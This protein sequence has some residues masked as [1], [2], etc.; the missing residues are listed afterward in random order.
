MT[1][2]SRKPPAAPPPRADSFFIV[3]VGAS[4]GGLEA[5]TQ[6]LG[7]LPPKPGIALV[8]IQ[9]LNPQHHSLL[10]EILS[11]TARMPIHEAVDNRAVEP[12]CIY[13]I[14]PNTNISIT[15]RI[16]RLTP[17]PDIHSPHLS[18]DFFLRSLAEDQKN[19]AIGVILSGNGS[20]G[21]TGLEAIKAEGGFTF[22][23][24]EASAKFTGM[25]H[26]AIASGNVDLVLPPDRIA[27]E[28]VRLARHSHSPRPGQIETLSSAKDG[29]FS[30]IF[31]EL[32][33][34]VGTDFSQYKLP[35]IQRRVHRRMALH[36]IET[37]ID[38]AKYLHG[39]RDETEKLYADLLINVTHF[40][41][42]PDGYRA[43]SKRALPRIL[44]ERAPDASIRIWTPGC[45]SGEETYS[46][47]IAVFEFLEKA[48]KNFPV[49]IFGTD[50]SEAS[51]E[52]ARKGIYPESIAVDVS[53]ERLRRFFVKVEGGY[54]ISKSIRDVCIFARHNLF[55]D[56]PFSRMDLVCCRNVL[57]YLGSAL[58][59]KVIPMLHYALRPGG[60]LFLGSSEGIS[61]F[62]H[63]FESVDKKQRIFVQRP[64]ATHVLDFGRNPLSVPVVPGTAK[65]NREAAES[66]SV[67]Q[68]EAD[69]IVLMNHAP[70]GVVIGGNMNV[71]QFRGRTSRYL[72]PAPGKASLNLL[73]MAKPSLSRALQTAT[74]EAKKTNQA[75]RREGVP[76]Q[77]NGE[78]GLLTIEV[79]PIRSAS[80]NDP[81]FLVLFEETVVGQSKLQPVS[82]ANVKKSKPAERREIGR[83]KMELEEAQE[84]IRAATE[85]HEAAD[86]ELRSANEE[87]LSANEELQSTNEELETSKEEMQSANEEM[88]TLNDE[89]RNRN[90]ELDQVNS[91]L[92]NL[93][94]SINI[95]ILMIGSDLRIRRFTPSADKAFNILPSDIGRP[96]TDIRSK[97]EV[98]DLERVILHVIDSLSPTIREVRDAQ[99]HWHSME[100][101]PYRT[102]E[103]KID[104]VVM[105]LIDIDG[106]KRA[107]EQDR[108]AR[109][110]YEA[111]IDTMPQPFLILDSDLRVIRANRAFFQTFHL[112][113][114]ETERKLVYQL[115]NGQWNIPELRRL[116][117]D[118]LP[119]VNEVKE[120]EVEHE[121]KSIGHRTMLL[122]A[123]QV[124]KFSEGHEALILLAIN[125]I[126]ESRRSEGALRTTEKLASAGRMAA[127]LAHEI[128]NPLESVTNLI[129]LARE[130]PGIPE[131]VQN[132]LKGI[133]E[134]LVRIGHLTKQTLGL[135]REST[136]PQRVLISDL[137]KALLSM[138]SPKIK[139][140]KIRTC[141][142]IANEVEITAMRGDLRQVFSNL[143][144]NSIDAVGI[145]GS[146][147]L[148]VAAIRHSANGRGGGVRVTVA[149]SG[150]G[151][152]AE[153][154]RKIFEPF[155]TTKKDVGTGLGL[156]ISKEIVEHHGGII[157]L[158]SC[159]VPGR[160]G[161]VI[162]VFLP[163]GAPHK[164]E[165]SE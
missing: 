90:H 21:T 114:K 22:A 3:G 112:E 69:R 45:A 108:K 127:T 123:R 97:I 62:S 67:V 6:L 139:I 130:E 95:P 1:P 19:N 144:C 116:L 103:N 153:T 92:V 76:H 20:D 107:A 150:S 124:K 80:P 5:L 39:H 14:P 65:A 146:I 136:A 94:G 59:K 2:R 141:L 73:R 52:K 140:R 149:D 17:R 87:V 104:G 64:S 11:K 105:V 25:P 49:Q 145:G 91:D 44:E 157:R 31:A 78:A 79:F 9:H 53:K 115:G 156:W 75:V 128:N 61:G 113:A 46:V 33:K 7:A 122:A 66:E 151:I 57:I 27:A 42:D 70:A 126:T 119:K 165:E 68:R 37:L 162:S 28:L 143:I 93:L 13:V 60:F 117:E 18:I 63:L 96:I 10:T 132:Y 159:V 88:T 55:N 83:L 133:D 8:L 109:E 148:R 106:Q 125:D 131:P 142:K 48:G 74:Q 98:P 110:F 135:Y 160:T 86:E 71:L 29:E 158:R 4:A 15:D 58:Q 16:L 121:F 163:D 100:V 51:L 137:L 84:A 155:F 54:Q 77:F 24:E 36:K 81:C 99:G 23:Q 50:I 152:P 147:H 34:V 85:A 89:L 43:L 118:V 47:A 56:P 138:L 129:Y 12:D 38:Y 82:T 26:S 35:T 30:G 161:T 101:R 72:E 164:E 40:F 120:F 32:R 154:L 41:R 134:E 102:V 111:L